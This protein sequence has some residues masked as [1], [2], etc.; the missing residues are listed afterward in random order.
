MII[1]R[2][3]IAALVLFPLSAFGQDVTA[4]TVPGNFVVTPISKTQLDL[5]W[6]ASTDA[7]G[8]TSYSV[9]RCQGICTP[10]TEAT[11]VSH[12]TTAYSD[13]GRP[14]NTTYSYC[15][16]AKD[17]ADNESACATIQ[18]AKTLD[19]AYLGM[20]HT[21]AEVTE[22]LSRSTSGP[23]KT[24]GDVSTN[25]PGDWDRIVSR[26]SDFL[27]TPS[28]SGWA[29]NTT[30]TCY[31]TTETSGLGFGTG[32]ELKDAAF[33]FAVTGNTT[34]RD[35]VKDQLLTQAGTTGTDWASTSLWSGATCLAILEETPKYGT[36]PYLRIHAWLTKLVIGYSYIRNYIPTPDRNTIDAWFLKGG[37]RFERHERISRAEKRFPNRNADNYD[38][39]G[40]PQDPAYN[41]YFGGNFWSWGQGSWANQ[42]A[43]GT[44]HFALVGI[45]LDNTYLKELGKRWFFEMVRYGMYPSGAIGDT[46]RWN[47]RFEDGLNVN[48]CKGFYYPANVLGPASY[49]AEAFA[50]TGDTSLYD[51]STTDGY[52]HNLGGP[53]SLKLALQYLHKLVDGTVVIYGTDD[54]GKATD[55]RYRID[56]DC[57]DFTSTGV[58]GA[59]NTK[60]VN[61]IISA[62]GNRYYQDTTLL[63]GYKHTGGGPGYLSN[64]NSSGGCGTGYEAAWCHMPGILF[65]FGQ[66]EN[67]NP[68]PTVSNCS[69]G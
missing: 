25:S 14:N 4:P 5:D 6:D 42:S 18:Y 7:V 51:Y 24:A 61:D 9:K 16:T 22:W 62:V 43:G 33:Y 13:T 1:T 52:P 65:Q 55:A 19:P 37:L 46:Y 41:L 8:V 68:Y 57:S 45:L 31:D 50:R 28:A 54:A 36:H 69:G 35:A 47:D 23:Y 3:F 63:N 30:G 10:T 48:P 53:K 2:L 59:T 20:F 34:Y 49:I 27:A 15:V 40:T 26:A 39:D 44:V 12:P 11:S 32:K 58:Q 29:G 21:E 67:I 66:M 17:A 60:H 64:P 56:G 38:E